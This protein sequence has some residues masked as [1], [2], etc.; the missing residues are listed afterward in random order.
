VK[1]ATELVA[2]KEASDV[3]MRNKKKRDFT[4]WTGVKSYIK[5]G[6]K[7]PS[8]LRDERRSVLRGEDAQKKEQWMGEL[9][10]S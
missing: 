7:V 4:L 10:P 1:K 6:T 2:L 3:G 8:G 5:K 9:S